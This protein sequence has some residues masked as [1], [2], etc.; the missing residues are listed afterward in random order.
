MR[1]LS[2]RNSCGVGLKLVSEC[3]YSVGRLLVVMF[4]FFDDYLLR[5]CWIYNL[6]AKKLSQ[7]KMVIGSLKSC[8]SMRM[9]CCVF[10]GYLGCMMVHRIDV[11][12]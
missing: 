3:W 8:K 1:R 11:I 12:T 7:G 5:F 4:W 9:V 6:V 10:S 2:T